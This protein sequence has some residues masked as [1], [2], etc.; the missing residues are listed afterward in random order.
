MKRVFIYIGFIFSGFV[1]GV[2]LAIAIANLLPANQ[3]KSMLTSRINA[4]TGH[5]LTI[6][7]DLDI[8]LTTRFA[9]KASEIRFSNAEWGSSPHM[10]SIGNLEGKLSLFPLLKGILDLTLVTD[11]IDLRLETDSAGQKNWEHGDLA[12]AAMV[13]LKAAEEAVGKNGYFP[14]S[15]LIRKLHLNATRIN[16]RDGQSG[17]QI[18]IYLEKLHAG[19]KDNKLAFALRGA[20]NDAPVTLDGGFTADGNTYELSN[21]HLHAG[22]FNVNGQAAL[23]LPPEPDGRPRLSGKFEVGARGHDRHPTTGNRAKGASHSPETRLVNFKEG[24]MFSSRPLPFSFLKSVDADIAVT[25][26]SLKT[27]GFQIEDLKTRVVLDNG[28]FKLNPMK[29]RVDKGIVEGTV[30]LNA[31]NSPASMAVDIE[32]T[33]IT[34]SDFGGK[35]HV[36]T[37]LKGSGDS[38]AAI[39]AGLDG[40][41]AIDIHDANL[42]KSVMTKFGADL[43]DSF[44]PFRQDAEN[45]RLICAIA[46]FDVK[47]GIADAKKKMAAQ[48]TDV[49]WFGGGN[50][51]LKTEAIEFGMY[52]VPRKGLGIHLGRLA[53]LVYVGGTLGQPIIVPDAKNMAIEY[54]NYAVAVGTGGLSLVAGRWWNKKRAN[55]DVCAEILKLRNIKGK[56]NEDLKKTTPEQ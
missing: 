21:L 20:Y 35:V 30:V 54:G 42:H 46:L 33:D 17:R 25:A 10:L 12:K 9:F 8:K 53:N 19:A 22:D 5:K 37:D 31:R 18:N 24:K 1:G 13:F 34:F 38:L 43:F 36:S 7:G 41:F 45:T 47:D 48:T 32:M 28:Q 55:T 51:N 29:A 49:T 26:K 4:A 16:F 3:Y 39:M 44:N 56:A 15:P 23:K 14:L 52:P 40:Q 6:D 27:H 2:F 11:K 50:V